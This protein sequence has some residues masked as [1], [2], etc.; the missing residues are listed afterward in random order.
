[1]SLEEYLVDSSLR[2]L[3]NLIL[4]EAFLKFEVSE[5]TSKKKYE[6]FLHTGIAD[7]AGLVLCF[8]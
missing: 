1:M 3:S 7:L 2:T 8:F 4:V 6:L 5:V